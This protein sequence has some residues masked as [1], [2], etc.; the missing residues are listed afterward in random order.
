MNEIA[1]FLH[2]GTIA[3][4][5]T[6]NALGVGIGEGIASSA[7]LK[8]INTQPAAKADIT[9]MAIIGM[10]L[11]ETA[12][13]LGLSIAIILLLSQTGSTVNYYFSIAELGI[14]AAVALPGCCIG[15]VSAYPTRAACLAVSRQPFFA[16]KI[17]RFMLITQS[18]IQTPIV[19]GFIIAMFIKTQAASISSMA[20][21]LRLVASGLSIGLGSIGPVIGMAHFA[22]IA[23]E[24]VGYNRAAYNKLFAF[25]FI[26]EAIIETPIIFSLVISTLLIVVPTTGRIDPLLTSIGMLAAALCTGLG[27]IGPGISSGRVA[28]SACYQ[29]AR[30][31]NLYGLLS[32]LSLF[33][34]GLIDTCA[35]YALLIALMLV[36]WV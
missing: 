20:E 30:N 14:A 21:A 9:N 24:G 34:Q 13:I 25:T 11:I 27:T 29:I 10:A 17:L 4:I 35:I 3:A 32:R 12:S 28:A 5:I 18:L 19:F 33:A 1:P 22:K 36:L 7:A 2:F 26:S 6:L 16:Q 31:P 15:I 23:C 8:A